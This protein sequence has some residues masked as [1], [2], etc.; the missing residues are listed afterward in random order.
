MIAQFSAYSGRI[1]WKQRDKCVAEGTQTFAK[2]VSCVTHVFNQ[3]SQ[4]KT[5]M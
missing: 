2:E 3:P 4:Q 1:I 5:D